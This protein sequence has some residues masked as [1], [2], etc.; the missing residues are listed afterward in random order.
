MMDKLEQLYQ[1]CLTK[2]KSQPDP[3]KLSALA[4]QQAEVAYLLL[5]L[6]AQKNGNPLDTVPY[7]GVSGKSGGCTFDLNKISETGLQVLS[8][9][10]S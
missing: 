7:Q 4:K 2:G 5:L 9:Y 1:Q 3:T 8:G 6:D 10:T